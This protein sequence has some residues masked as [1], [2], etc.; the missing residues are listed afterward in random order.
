MELK[1][2]SETLAIKK[3]K[4]IKIYY[5]VEFLLIFLYLEIEILKTGYA[6]VLKCM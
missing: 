6:A 3:V 5:K 4:T 2:I 1:S